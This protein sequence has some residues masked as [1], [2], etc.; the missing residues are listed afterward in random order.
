MGRGTE[1]SGP[2]AAGPLGV[3]QG[4]T[5]GLDG[6]RRRGWGRAE[7]PSGSSRLS[8]QGGLTKPIVG[9]RVAG[10]P[11]RGPRGGAGRGASTLR[12][13]LP[14]KVPPSTQAD[15]PSPA[16][17]PTRPTRPEPKVHA[18]TWRRGGRGPPVRTPER[19]RPAAERKAAPSPA[20]VLQVRASRWRPRARSRER[21]TREDPHPPLPPGPRSGGDSPERLRVVEPRRRQGDRVDRDPL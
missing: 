20:P 21:K 2:T 9:N 15:G 10:R 3:D 12:C 1:G 17:R 13:R 14:S 16:T 8:V 11:G 7:P 4:T 19:R 18:R 6:N 5:R